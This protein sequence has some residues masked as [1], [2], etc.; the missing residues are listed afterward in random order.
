MKPS[1]VECEALGSIAE[2]NKSGAGREGAGEGEGLN[3]SC[4]GF[5]QPVGNTASAN[6]EV[7]AR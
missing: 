6:D 3:T 2:S 5:I 1:E 7:E 4:Q